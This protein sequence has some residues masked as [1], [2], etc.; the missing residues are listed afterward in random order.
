MQTPIYQ[1][2]QVPNHKICVQ[3]ALAHARKVY[4]FRDDLA[5]RSHLL[6]MASK[7]TKRKATSEPLE[8][9]ISSSKM[10]VTPH[11]KKR[12]SD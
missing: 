11:P 2:P 1:E 4:W 5:A 7:S 8:D 10:T 9:A 6:Q 12:Q 3:F